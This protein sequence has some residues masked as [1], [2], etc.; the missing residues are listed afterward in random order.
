MKVVRLLILLA[1]LVAGLIIG[2]LNSDK[3]VLSLGFTQITTTTGLAI[4]VALLTGALIGGGIVL[5]SLVIP[6]Y[7][8]LRKAQKASPTV[9]VAP[10]STPSSTFDGR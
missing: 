2:A 8:K 1:V 4:I 5:A 3:M 9:V 7:A 10:A 6:L